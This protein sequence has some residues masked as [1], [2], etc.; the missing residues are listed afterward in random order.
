[1][2]KFLTI[3]FA[4]LFLFSGMHL[5]LASHYCGGELAAVRWSANGELATCGMENPGEAAPKGMIL[6]ETCCQ[7]KLTQNTVDQQYQF[8]TFYPKSRIAPQIGSFAIP[9][10]MLLRS[11]ITTSNLFSHVFPPGDVQPSEVKQ[12]A[13]C[14]YLI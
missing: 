8:Q 9:S 12:E 11:P 6:H 7:D 1:M 14:V 3:A 4:L 13:V 5:K 2:K 10:C